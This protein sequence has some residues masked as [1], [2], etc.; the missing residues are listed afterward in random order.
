MTGPQIRDIL[1]RV[2]D[3]EIA[4]EN[5]GDLDASSSFFSSAP[6][7]GLTGA[8]CDST[9]SGS[10]KV[11]F[12]FKTGVQKTGSLRIV[13]KPMAVSVTPS[14]SAARSPLLS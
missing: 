6:S 12:C 4:P 8:Q 2:P 10:A 7:S 13:R 3:L 9:A 14:S 1:R 5:Y 11:Q